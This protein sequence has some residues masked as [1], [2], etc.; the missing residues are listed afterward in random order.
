M[1]V[2]TEK[3]LVQI[4]ADISDLRK[5]LIDGKKQVESFGSDVKK[6]ATTLG[7]AFGAREVFNFFRT[8]IDE[9]A[10][11]EEV[12]A[13]LTRALQNQGITSTKTRDQI[14]EYSKSLQMVSTFDD[15]AITGVQTLL[16]S[17]GRLSG[18]GLQRAT[19]A[20]MDLATGLG[21]DLE[22]AARLV[23]K[24]AAGSA[25]A[26][27]RYGIVV[28]STGDKAKDFESV[29]GQVEGRFGGQAAASVNT[30]AGAWKQLANAFGDLKETLGGQALPVLTDFAKGVKEII[31]FADDGGIMRLAV[32]FA[33]LGNSE[34]L[35]HL[36][37]EGGLLGDDTNLSLQRDRVKELAAEVDILNA[38]MGETP[39]GASE[40]LLKAFDAKLK[41]LAVA[42]AQLAK[43]EA[44]GTTTP[45]KPGRTA[46][47]IAAEEKAIRDLDKAETD[48]W[49][50]QL[51][52]EDDAEAA[53][54]ARMEAINEIIRKHAEEQAAILKKEQEHMAQDAQRIAGIMESAFS[55]AF[56][57]FVDGSL[58]AK[59]AM[60]QLVREIT[61]AIAK[62]IILRAV[63]A[64]VAGPGG[65]ALAPLGSLIAPAF[66]HGGV[67][68]GASSRGD[69]KLIRVNSGEEVLRR[70]DPRHVRNMGRAG[71]GVSISATVQE[72]P[73][74]PRSPAEM[75][76]LVRR[77]LK[78]ALETLIDSGELRVVRA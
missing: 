78:D 13:K 63:M 32:A 21:I 75:A 39:K 15:E 47:D 45:S 12:S 31:G 57:S 16:I 46:E 60:A 24:A 26:F 4:G 53:H 72:S 73:F 50:T 10:K 52:R 49:L 36:K 23:G 51:Q 34:L 48:L 28:K 67:V 11:A 71:G 69:R 35:R 1:A 19:R 5:K 54:D 43:M 42:K 59:E 44:A 20:T 30:F 66:A 3:L 9:A 40:S 25:E 22:S 8:T 18:E 74:V 58:S 14:L 41:E 7:V 55:S 77:E 56:D 61:L 17:L 64:E 70:D 37:R 27:S 65:A 33:T 68:P 6:L 76:R 2:D 29:L 38:A 62:A